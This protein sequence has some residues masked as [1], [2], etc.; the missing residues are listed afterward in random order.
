M[1]NLWI[2][3]CKKKKTVS[4]LLKERSG[5]NRKE[6]YSFEKRINTNITLWGYK[7]NEVTKW[8]YKK[9]EFKEF[10]TKGGPNFWWPNSFSKNQSF[11]PKSYNKNM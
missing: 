2:L 9:G 1:G 3:F 6:I 4:Q 5:F 7:K 11:Y 8:G 10:E